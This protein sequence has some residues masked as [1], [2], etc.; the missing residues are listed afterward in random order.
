MWADAEFYA[1]PRSWTRC[2]IGYVPKVLD[3]T[4]VTIYGGGCHID[5]V[6]MD[7]DVTST[8]LGR[9]PMS[10]RLRLDGCRCHID[11]VPGR[12]IRSFA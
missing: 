11:C 8:A 1:P 5:C 3:V 4:S 6:W 7:A 2:P 9:V 12:P 10:H